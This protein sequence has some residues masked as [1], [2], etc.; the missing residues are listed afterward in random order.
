MRDGKPPNLRR[1]VSVGVAEFLIV[2]SLAT[3][4]PAAIS[5]PPIVSPPILVIPSKP[6]SGTLVAT[7]EFDCHFFTDSC[8]F[9]YTLQTQAI[10]PNGPLVNVRWHDAGT[11]FDLAATMNLY[12][13]RKQWYFDVPNGA[14]ELFPNPDVGVGDVDF[15][16]LTGF[17]NTNA[18][19]EYYVPPSD[20]IPVEGILDMLDDVGES[21]F[22]LYNGLVENPTLA[23]YTSSVERLDGGDY[24]YSYSVTNG[25]GTPLTYDWPDAG[26]SGE[27]GIGESAATTFD[28]PLLPFAV[29]GSAST[30]YTED[31]FG[32]DY[33]RTFQAPASAII[34]FSTMSPAIPEPTSLTVWLAL[35]SSLLGVGRASRHTGRYAGTN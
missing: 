16:G 29:V 22:E 25:A 2:V 7:S 13:D 15:S 4:T 28:S 27:L 23:T 19:A 26:L 17:L 20:P 12:G 10:D 3:V 33:L 14:L 18:Q 6:A 11:N 32:T 34:P 1:T 21:L 8:R 9:L 30:S 35:I 24:R 5:Q 31:I